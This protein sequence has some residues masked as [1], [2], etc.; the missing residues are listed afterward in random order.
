MLSSGP[1][2]KA[3]VTTPVL[4]MY[5]VIGN[6]EFSLGLHEMS[7]HPFI[8]A[9]KFRVQDFWDTEGWKMVAAIQSFNM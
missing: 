8:S 7:F 6:P 1:A 4:S 3:I 2:L 5:P 9:N